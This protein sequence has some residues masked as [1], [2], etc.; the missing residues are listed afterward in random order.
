MKYVAMYMFF[1]VVISAIL[2]EKGKFNPQTVNI[3]TLH[4]IN[5][6]EGMFWK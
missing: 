2:D 4:F 5:W 6:G 3:S 1:F